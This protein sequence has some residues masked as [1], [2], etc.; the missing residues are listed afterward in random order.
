M[1][2]PT[3][4]EVAGSNAVSNAK[5]SAGMRP[6]AMASIEYGI[7]VENTPTAASITT[8]VQVKSTRSASPYKNGKDTTAANSAPM[9]SDGPVIVGGSAPFLPDPF[10]PALLDPAP[11]D[12][13]P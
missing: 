13:G 12:S 8:R 1:M 2:A 10:P 11:L 9:A 4:V 7:A 3:K 6:K 5:V